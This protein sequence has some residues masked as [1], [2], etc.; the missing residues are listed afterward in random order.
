MLRESIRSNLEE[1]GFL[2]RRSVC[3]KLEIIFE[4]FLY[5]LYLNLNELM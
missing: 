2:V 3:P 4:I 1:M 5:Y